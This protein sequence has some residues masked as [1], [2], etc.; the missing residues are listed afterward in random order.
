MWT[1]ILLVLLALVFELLFTLWGWALSHNRRG[2]AILATSLMPLANLAGIIFLIEATTTWAR[3][4]VCIADS[5]G[6][7]LGAATVLYLLPSKVEHGHCP[8]SLRADPQPEQRADP[9]LHPDGRGLP[10]QPLRIFDP[11][12]LSE[13]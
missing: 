7:A 1:F 11:E 4:G 13:R 10:L 5:I 8:N 9:V 6:S 12:R 3:A 2:L